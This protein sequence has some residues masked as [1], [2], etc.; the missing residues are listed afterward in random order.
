MITECRTGGHWMMLQVKSY[1]Y[2]LL[3]LMKVSFFFYDFPPE[4]PPAVG[5][6][7]GADADHDGGGARH[8]R[9]FQV[10]HFQKT[11]WQKP[12]VSYTIGFGS[13]RK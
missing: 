3:V 12:Q 9:Q 6:L 11:N 1:L 2:Y 4:L 13:Q 5:F 7:R 8:S 10:K